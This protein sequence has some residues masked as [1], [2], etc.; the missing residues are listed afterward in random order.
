MK[1]VIGIIAVIFTFVGYIPYIMD[2]IKGKTKPHI[3][4]WFI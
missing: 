2:T 3:Y 1:E 4:S